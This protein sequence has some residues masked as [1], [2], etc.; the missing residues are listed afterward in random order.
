[1]KKTLYSLMLSDDVVREIDA[2]AHRLGTNRSNLINQILAEHVDLV[3]PERR[4]RDIFSRMESLLLGDRELVPH[5]APNAMSMSLKSSLQ[6][7]YRPTVKYSVEL[8][9]DHSGALGELSVVFRTQSAELL[10]AMERYFSV[11]KCIEDELVAPHIPIEYALYGGRFTRSICLPGKADYSTEAIAAAISAYIRL[12]D[13]LMKAWLGGA[14]RAALRRS[15][16]QWIAAGN[17][18]L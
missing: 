13:S 4:I 17:A 15:Y 3:T 14:D 8:F 12:F 11:L 6:Y 18:L 16:V 10:E 2:L 7:R 1:M 5:V 9:R